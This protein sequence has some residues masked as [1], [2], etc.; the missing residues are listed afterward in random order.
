[1]VKFF[2]LRELIEFIK[3]R[4]V[5]RTTE[6]ECEALVR[7]FENVV[8]FRETIKNSKMSKIQTTIVSLLTLIVS[9][10]GIATVIQLVDKAFG[11]FDPSKA[12]ALIF[13]W[14][15]GIESTLIVLVLILAGIIRRIS[16][17][18]LKEW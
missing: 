17:K 9:F 7:N 3:G 2:S 16:K 6:S 11:V 10:G 18:R 13:W 14:T 12:D 15:L 1:M 8:Q 4:Q 5:I